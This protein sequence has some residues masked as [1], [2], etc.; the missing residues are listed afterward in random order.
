MQATAAQKCVKMEKFKEMM[1]AD[2]LKRVAAFKEP[3]IFQSVTVTTKQ[4]DKSGYHA[5]SA[6]YM[7]FFFAV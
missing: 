1:F 6:A 4:G 7:A 2:T 5:V 3:Q